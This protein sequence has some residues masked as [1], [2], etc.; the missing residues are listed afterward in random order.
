S[1][2]SRSGHPD[3]ST[4]RTGKA[5]A[6][7]LRGRG[8]GRDAEVRWGFPGR[9]HPA[10]T[11]DRPEREAPG[12]FRDRREASDDARAVP[13][14]GEPDR[15]DT[16]GGIEDMADATFPRLAFRYPFDEAAASDAESRG[17]LSYAF[18]ESRNGT[19][20]PVVFYDPV[21]LQQDL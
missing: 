7:A 9:E 18:V 1:G 13:G 4:D 6:R 21:R 11:E 15:V 17:Y 14:I 12:A 2:K 20:Y 3:R 10:G 19:R 16:S 8:C 5:H